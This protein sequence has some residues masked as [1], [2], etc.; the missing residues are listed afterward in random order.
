MDSFES[1]DKINTFLQQS[2]IE[3]VNRNEEF[4]MFE[5]IVINANPKTPKKSLTEVILA[6]AMMTAF[7]SS[8]AQS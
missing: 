7:R 3:M 4:K 6:A 8:H 2:Q 5:T 1:V